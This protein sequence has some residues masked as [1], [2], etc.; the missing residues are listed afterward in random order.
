M[1][2]HTYAT[3]L[4]ENKASIVDISNRLGHAS[5]ETTL[6]IYLHRTTKM[7]EATNAILDEKF[8]KIS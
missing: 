3:Q 2:R 8:I 5:T 4:L 7:A 1:L 6:N